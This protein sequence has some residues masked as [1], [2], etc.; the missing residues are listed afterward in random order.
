MDF[1]IS[2]NRKRIWSLKNVPSFYHYLF[3][4]DRFKLFC[5]KHRIYY[6]N[7]NTKNRTSIYFEIQFDN[8]WFI[9]RFSN[10]IQ[11][12][13]YFSPV[14]FTVFN[15]N[16]YKFLKKTLKKFVQL[17]YGYGKGL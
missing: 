16:D 5:E 12:V 1:S 8:K 15:E 2:K 11:T 9:I 3:L 4:A 10:H 13:K 14:D 6:I 17:S 7:R